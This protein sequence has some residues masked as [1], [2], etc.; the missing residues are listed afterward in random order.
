MCVCVCTQTIHYIGTS[1][2]LLYN[3]ITIFPAQKVDTVVIEMEVV[4]G[5]S[6]KSVDVKTKI[7]T[8]VE[9]NM[10]TYSIKD[11]SATRGIRSI[12]ISFS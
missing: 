11:V 9:D 4:F 1:Y 12:S 8:Q 3:C 10:E 7:D 6:S 2:K 5:G